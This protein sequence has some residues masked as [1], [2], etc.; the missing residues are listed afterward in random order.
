MDSEITS[1]NSVDEKQLELIRWYINLFDSR[2]ASLESRAGIT[3]S[4]SSLLFGG[5]L[6]LIERT[7]DD[8]S[9][10]HLF[11]RA[12]LLIS[13]ALVVVL[14]AGAIVSATFAIANIWKTS[15]RMFRT[16]M[17][18]RLFF[19]PRATFERFP[20]FSL[21]REG[22][23]SMKS[24]DLKTYM[25]GELWVLSNEYHNRYQNLRRSIRLLSFA[26]IPAIMALSVL[27]SKYFISQP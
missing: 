4:I 20:N 25:L 26:I 6:F 15:K 24:D 23:Q 22:F 2:R 17:P 19:Y 1:K 21:Y 10:Y 8:I 27:F 14:L 16:D 12:L 7:L 3:V 13:V 5:F 9:Y 11:A 18:E